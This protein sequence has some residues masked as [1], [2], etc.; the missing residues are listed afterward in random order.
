MSLHDYLMGKLGISTSKAEPERVK[1]SSGGAI[2]SRTAYAKGGPGKGV[3]GK[4][5]DRDAA[6]ARKSA[7]KEKSKDREP[8][9]I[10]NDDSE[11]GGAYLEPHTPI[12]PRSYEKNSRL[13]NT[14]VPSIENVRRIAER[15][16][17]RARRLNAVDNLAALD[18]PGAAAPFLDDGPA[19]LDDVFKK[20]GR[21]KRKKKSSANKR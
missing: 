7:K 15:H 21:I 13:L 9:I 2:K 4:K 5:Y 14:K 6:E 16:S 20:G 1:R 8:V 3:P 12:V 18:N 10:T 11:M 19:H 17:G